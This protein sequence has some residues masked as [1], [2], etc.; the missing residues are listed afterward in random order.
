M[1]I[2]KRNPVLNLPVAGLV[3]VVLL[4]GETGLRAQEALRISMAG[5]LAA[6]GRK[7]AASSVGYYNLLWGAA[8]LALF[9]GALH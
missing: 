9:G 4:L 5:D 1:V 7:Q 8:R 6:A 3:L 2:T